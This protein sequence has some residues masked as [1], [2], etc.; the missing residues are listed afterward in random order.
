MC[1]AMGKRIKI[2]SLQVKDVHEMKE[3]GNHTNP[4]FEDYNFPKLNDEEIEEW[5]RIKT[6]KRNKKCYSVYNEEGKV[7]GYLAIKDIKRFRKRATLGIVFDP[8]YINK[9][10]GTE[11]IKT[12]LNYYF[13]QLNMKILILHVA[14][15]NKRA[16]RCYEKCGFVKIKEYL[17]KLESQNINVFE[18]DMFKEIRE[19]FV[20]K[21]GVI[22]NYFHV[23]KIGKKQFE[24]MLSTGE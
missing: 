24:Q 1:I 17:K 2:C 15:F 9:G 19:D 6:G 4:L 11:T 10:Y 14:R 12:F 3:W 21:K 7:I 18:H 20:I 22:Y 16:I 23:M 13:T 8:N 5:F